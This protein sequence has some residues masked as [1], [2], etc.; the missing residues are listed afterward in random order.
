MSYDHRRTASST[1]L[2]SLIDEAEQKFYQEIAKILKKNKKFERCDVAGGNVHFLDF[3]GQDKSDL[4][5]DGHFNVVIDHNQV[6]VNFTASHAYRGSLNFSKR[7]PLGT[8][9]VDDA[10]EIIEEQLGLRD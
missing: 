7:Y 3:K 8:F 10:V 2:L 1:S 4:D 9:T 5:F 6:W